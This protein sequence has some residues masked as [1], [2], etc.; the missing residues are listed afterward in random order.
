[1]GGLNIFVQWRTAHQEGGDGT[2]Y[3]PNVLSRRFREE[4]AFPAVY[5]WRAMRQSG[6]K[7][8]IYIG[9]AEE[10]ARRMRWVLTPHS[11]AKASD[12][13]KRLNQIF[14]KLVSEGKKIVIDVADITPFE[15]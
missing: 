4:Y 15:I 11:S 7:E 6:E 8:K 5:R 3:F 1:M 2:Y 14:T 13:N 9:E 10:L 12:T